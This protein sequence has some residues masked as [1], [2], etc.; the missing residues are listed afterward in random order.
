MSVVLR[1]SRFQEVRVAD[2]AETDALIE[3]ETWFAGGREYL[4][5]D[6]TA[7][8]LAGDGFTTTAEPGYGDGPYGE[9]FYGG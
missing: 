2:P 3:G 1:N 7:T 4:V 8:L 9:D 6:A 5:S